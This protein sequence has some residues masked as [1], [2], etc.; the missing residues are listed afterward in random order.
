MI[1]SQIFLNFVPV[2]VIF[3]KFLAA[4]GGYLNND[5]TDF[6]GLKI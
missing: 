4:I 5:L 1:A 3:H 6:Q 2:K